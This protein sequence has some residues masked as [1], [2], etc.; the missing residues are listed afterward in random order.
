MRAAIWV[1]ID[2]QWFELR[3]QSDNLVYTFRRSPG[4]NGQAA[5]QR[6]DGDYWIIFRSDLGWVA[7]DDSTESCMGRPWDV[8]PDAQGD[9]PPEGVWV[10]RKGSK[11][12]VYDLAYIP[13]P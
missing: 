2:H 4:P 8:M 1:M 10:S 5:Y 7:W 12:Y 9:F 6:Q 3:R 13:A 11:S